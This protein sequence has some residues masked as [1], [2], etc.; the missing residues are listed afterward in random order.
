MR[1]LMVSPEYPPILGG[2]GRYTFNLVNALKKLDCE[3]LVLSDEKGDGNY[4][5]ISP[6]N[7][8]NSVVLPQIGNRFT[9]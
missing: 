1:I 2:I 8:D 5:G 3:V 9:Y 4:K 6:S 7:T